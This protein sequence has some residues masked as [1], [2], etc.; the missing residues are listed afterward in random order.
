[1]INDLWRDVKNGD[2]VAVSL[3]IVMLVPLLLF[4]KLFFYVVDSS[5]LSPDDVK[6]SIVS[7]SFSPGYFQPQVVQAGTTTFTNMTWIPDS[8]TITVAT[9]DITISC[10]ATE[11][12]YNKATGDVTAFLVIGRLS[13]E[14]YC[15]GVTLPTKPYKELK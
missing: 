6:A 14:A 2:A 7:R 13:G 15:K 9:R 1:M 8:W 12:Q 3:V 11:A 10:P 5:F 4:S